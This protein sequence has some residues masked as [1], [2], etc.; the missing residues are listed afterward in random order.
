MLA[1]YNQG[2]FFS[3]IVHEI[4]VPFNVLVLGLDTVMAD[5]K[6]AAADMLNPKLSALIES[7]VSM[8]QVCCSVCACMYQ[9]NA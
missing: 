1:S 8:M 4:R 6:S 2:C 7:N 9:C 5:V 3:Q